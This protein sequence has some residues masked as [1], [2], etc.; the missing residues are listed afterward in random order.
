MN[1][2]SRLQQKI[3][4]LPQLSSLLHIWRLHSDTIVF[5]NGCFDLLHE[6]HIHT[7]AKAK[8]EGDRLI[9]GLNSDASTTQLKG[10][11]RPINNEQQRALV[12]A[13]LQM[14]DLVVVFTEDTP[15]NLIHAIQPDV[16]VKGGDYTIDQIVGA[17][18]V[19]AYGGKVVTIPL[20]EGMSTTTIESRLQGRK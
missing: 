17:E 14:V 4:T 20:V 2:L 6:G 9:V 12:L 3:V 8:D 11:D 10:P 19:Q 13:A 1:H 5:T 7:L 15:E 18:F 16:L